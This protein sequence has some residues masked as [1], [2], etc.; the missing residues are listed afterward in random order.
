MVRDI[1]TQQVIV[2]G[3]V[4]DSM[5]GAAPRARPGVALLRTDDGRPVPG[6]AARVGA[7]GLY[8]FHADPARALAPQ[9]IALQVRV[10]A[11]GYR[12]A[13]AAV[14]FTAADLARVARSVAGG[15]VAVIAGVPITRDIALEPLPVALSGRVS[16]ADDRA[17]PIAGATV[18]L[19]APA[20][21]GPVPT[22]AEG[23]FTLSPLPVAPRVTLSITAPGHR[24]ASIEHIVDFR[25]PINRGSFTL[26]PS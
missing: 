16:E 2:S 21:M 8:A 24:P 9:A 7:D 25:N 11:P 22:D 19:T 14:D 23:W 13:Q 20:A 1:L 26:E 18:T 3:R 17:Q 5:S 10:T 4:S 6:V 12:P 15:T